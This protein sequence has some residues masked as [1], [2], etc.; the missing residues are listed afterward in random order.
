MMSKTIRK[1]L[2]VLSMLSLIG[3]PT[4][5]VAD[6]TD[7]INF[8][9]SGGSNILFVMDM[10]GSM[11]W[12][13]TG[14]NTPADPADSR[15]GVLY[16]SLK[17]VL[18]D[19]SL[20]DINIGVT[21]F[22]GKD[23]AGNSN[24]NAHGIAYPVSPIDSD[25][26]VQL[27]LNSGFSHKGTSYLPVASVG[28]PAVSLT[29]R[30][31]VGNSVPSTWIPSSW[32]PIVDALYEAALYFRGAAVDW[33]NYTPS[34]LRSAHPSTYTGTFG[35][36]TNPPIYKSPITHEC[37]NNAIVLLSDGR[38]TANLAAASVE[39]LVG[40]GCN[41]GTDAGRCGMELAS[42]LATND[43]S[44]SIS[45]DQ[46]VKTHVIGVALD[47]SASGKEASTYL[48]DIATS[49]GGEFVNAATPDGLASALK[50][51]ITLVSKARSF[52]SPTY[53]P[54]LSSLLSHSDNVYLPVFDRGVGPIWSGNL[55]KFKLKDGKLIDANGLDA[56][57]IE[58]SL[59]DTAKD[60]WA[61]GASTHSI[62]SGGAAFKIN[63]VTRTVYTDNGSSF[64]D[65]DTVT[66]AQLGVADSTENTEL[67][68]FIR[69]EKSDGSPR[70]HMG[71]IIHSKPVHVA[72]GTNDQDKVIFVGTN[73]GFLHAINDN[74]GT[75]L[76]AYM[77]EE[78][79]KSIKIQYENKASEKRLY[80]VDGQITLWHEDTNANRIVDNSEKA[81]LYFGL[82][83]G[84]KSYYAVDV[85]NRTN[86]V[87]LW[88]I[89]N[90][91]KEFKDLGYSWSQPVRAMMRF[92]KN[93]TAK[94]V[95]VFG[96]GYIDDLAGSTEADGT[97]RAAE[98]YIVDA[99][100]GKL[101]WKTSDSKSTISPITSSTEAIKYT[102]P[103][104]I[105][106]LDVDKNGSLDRLYFGDTGGNIWRVDFQ[107][108][109]KGSSDARVMH[110]AS[111]GAVASPATSRR[112]FFVEPD[113]A[114]F[115]HGGTYVTSVSIGSG[116]R[117]KPLDFTGDDHFFA[118]F[119]ESPLKT[120]KSTDSAVTIPPTITISDLVEATTAPVKNAL[121]GGNKGWFIDL[122]KVKGEKVLSSAL[123]YNNMVMFTTLGATTVTITACGIQSENYS[124]FYALDLLTGAAVFDLDG[125]TD[126]KQTTTSGGISVGA[127][128]SDASKVVTSGEI[129]ET[130]QIVFDKLQASSGGSCVKG[131]CLRR[132]EVCVNGSSDCID[133]PAPNRSLRK[134]FWLDKD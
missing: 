93:T 63:P 81:I 119:D 66:D 87:L 132:E 104:R 71:D 112:M 51:T 8:E 9:Y 67:V 50:N 70:Y 1:S 101:I 12:S 55:K 124:M 47:N 91:K 13:L 2:S 56:I 117:P 77:P 58:G 115:M 21:S 28:V 17:T 61:T 3:L 20:T 34:D 80:G 57:S 111:L 14:S 46:F 16:E 62:K 126:V 103:A 109:Y 113:I 108:A 41:T 85:S 69:G 53:T 105:R 7:I 68:N 27:N 127:G 129:L 75:E 123:T 65:I 76:F 82:R 134:V 59:K 40:G 86:P 133:I 107:P 23:S 84:G 10:S 52:T 88:R 97:G 18:N 114:L 33:G 60:F 11:A 95:L 38:P 128:V 78:L 25:A 15:R 72:Y 43:N 49:G 44:G 42:Y 30:G 116:E 94:P 99:S 31:Y 22:S 26:Q 6:D 32:T 54:D 5:T 4:I 48:N 24:S 73:E 120:Y 96:G 79:L 89:D 83:R 131:D 19:P 130:P 125:D 102:V 74:D 90:S 110:F 92:E 118:M 100:N 45:G 35:D 29:T 98:V 64:V 122:V 36:S 121:T 106:V 39:S 37:S